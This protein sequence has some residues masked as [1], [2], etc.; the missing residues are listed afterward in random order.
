MASS[1]VGDVYVW[2]GGAQ[3]SFGGAVERR[4]SLRPEPGNRFG[5]PKTHGDVCAAPILIAAAGAA[6][7]DACPTFAVDQLRNGV[8]PLNAVV[9]RPKERRLV[10][11]WM[12]KRLHWQ[13]A[14][15]AR[16]QSVKKVAKFGQ[17]RTGSE[18]ETEADNL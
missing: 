15:I 2:N 18:S 14:E 6:F 10:H 7:G 16:Q 5:T 13:A 3:T 9:D 11:M 1:Q 17:L 8:V 4:R 12:G